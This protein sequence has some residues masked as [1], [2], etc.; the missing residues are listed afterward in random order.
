M[1]GEIRVARIKSRW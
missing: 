1:E